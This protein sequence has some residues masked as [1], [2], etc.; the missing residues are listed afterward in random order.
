M[1]LWERFKGLRGGAAEPILLQQAETGQVGKE[2]LRRATVFREQ[3]E[4]FI[5][6]GRLLP[7]LALP[8]HQGLD[9]CAS[10][11]SPLAA[12]GRYRCELCALA[13]KLALEGVP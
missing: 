2:I 9:G 7:V 3:A 1:D 10:C 13:V 4:Q 5:R 8:E 11:G 6:Q 12:G